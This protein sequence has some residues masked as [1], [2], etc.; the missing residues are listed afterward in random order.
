MSLVTRAA[1]A[2]VDTSTAMFAPQ[3]TGNLYAG[4]ALDVCAPCYIKA[5]DGKVYMSNGTAANEAA[6]FDGF[7]PRA[8]AIGEPVTLLGVG[9]RMRYGSGLTIGASYFVAATAGRLDT[10]A[11]TGGTV[12]IARAINATDIRVILNAA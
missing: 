11:T 9:A 3:L 10:A 1:Q 6:K 5:S 2:S 12:A 4:E 7:T 8:C